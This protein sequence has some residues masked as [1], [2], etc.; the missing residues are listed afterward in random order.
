MRVGSSIVSQLESGK[1][2]KSV[3]VRKGRVRESSRKTSL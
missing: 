1:K 2:N 3:R